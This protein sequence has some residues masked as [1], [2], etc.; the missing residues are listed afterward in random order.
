MSCQVGSAPFARQRWVVELWAS[1]E[2]AE[3]R[4]QRSKSQ[5]SKLRRN[6]PALA[7]HAA[8]PTSQQTAAGRD[9]VRRSETTVSRVLSQ[10]AQAEPL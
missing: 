4:G 2:P 7:L 8:S 10:C 9:S 6:A 5:T 3:P 1:Q